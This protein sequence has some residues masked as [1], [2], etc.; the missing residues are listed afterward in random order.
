[1]LW[2]PGVSGTLVAA[3]LS[4]SSWN[5]HAAACNSLEFFL[6]LFFAWKITTDILSSKM[7]RS[8]DLT[9]QTNGLSIKIPTEIC[10][11]ESAQ[12]RGFLAC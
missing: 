4:T 12:V 3:S 10:G 7:G 5:R 11:N 1:M 8:V 2:P 6:A 9:A